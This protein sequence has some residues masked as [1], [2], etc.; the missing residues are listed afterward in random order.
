MARD[1]IL[2]D[3]QVLGGGQPHRSR[4]RSS[5]PTAGYGEEG[6][7]VSRARHVTSPPRSYHESSRVLAG[8]EQGYAQWW[9]NGLA[10]VSGHIRRC[11]AGVET[12]SRGSNAALMT[13]L[14]AE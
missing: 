2:R 7:A 13:W 9:M 4:P 3:F 1:S 8:C 12:V 5:A 10:R 6:G 14:Q 11:D